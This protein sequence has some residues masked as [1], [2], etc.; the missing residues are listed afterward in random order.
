[1]YT[2]YVESLTFGVGAGSF[3]ALF[4]IIFLFEGLHSL[5]PVTSLIDGINQQCTKVRTV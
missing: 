2:T 3:V 4:Y 1:M 5:S